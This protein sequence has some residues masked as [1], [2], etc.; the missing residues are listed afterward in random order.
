MSTEEIRITHEEQLE[1]NH[2]KARVAYLEAQW[3]R[4]KRRTPYPEFCSTP[5]LCANKGVC[6]RAWVCND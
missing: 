1:I 6:Q 4:V 5:H 3:D 2:L